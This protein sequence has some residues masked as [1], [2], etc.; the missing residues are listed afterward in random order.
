MSRRPN[1]SACSTPGVST[2]NDPKTRS[3]NR[4]ATA[5]SEADVYR[6]MPWRAPGT[7]VPADPWCVPARLRKCLV[8]ACVLRVADDALLCSG[9]AGGDQHGV[10]QTA[11]GEYYETKH[12]KLGDLGSKTLKPYFSGANW[13]PGEIVNVSWFIQAK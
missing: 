13:K 12:A 1:Y 3:I 6:Y 10:K 9:V 11:G 7:A 4:G 5:G 8:P 2:N